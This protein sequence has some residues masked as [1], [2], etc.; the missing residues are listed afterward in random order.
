MPKLIQA[1]E[2]EVLIAMSFWALGHPITC[3]I[4][5]VMSGLKAM[6]DDKKLV[7]VSTTMVDGLDYGPANLLFLGVTCVLNLIGYAYIRYAIRLQEKEVPSTFLYL[8]FISYFGLGILLAFP[9]VKLHI[10]PFD[11]G[12]QYFGFQIFMIFAIGWIGYFSQ[13]VKSSEGRAGFRLALLVA[14]IL[15]VTSWVLAAAINEKNAAVAEW[16]SLG[17]IMACHAI[18]VFTC[19]RDKYMKLNSNG[20]GSLVSANPQE[21]EQI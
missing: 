16:S 20:F 2:H 1:K 17:I 5:F 7:S 13:W 14:A 4:G 9:P 12:I 18:V 3:M 21:Y 8:F 10:S 19:E 6:S 15:L 11:Y